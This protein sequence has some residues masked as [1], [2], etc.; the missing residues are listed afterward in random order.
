LEPDV[1]DTRV[2]ILTPENA[3]KAFARQYPTP[4]PNRS[5]GALVTYGHSFLAEGSSAGLTQPQYYAEILAK[6]L[7][8]TYPTLSTGNDLKRAVG[9]SLIHN[10]LQQIASIQ[11]WQPGTKGMVLLQAMLN[12]LGVEGATPQALQ[13]A[14]NG[15]RAAGAF[16]SA[17]QR[18]EL[19][20][21]ARWT[22]SGTWATSSATPSASGT[23]WRSTTQQNAYIEFVAPSVD[24]YLILIG[25]SGAADTGPV[26]AITD[27]TTGGSLGT[28]D[29][30]QQTTAAVNV[31]PH[32]YR[33]PAALGGHLLRFTKSDA[34]TNSLAVD[35]LLPQAAQPVPLLMMKEP[36]L[37]D[38]STS[39][40]FPS[41]SDAAIDAFNA[42]IDEV[43]LE[44]GNIIVADPNGSGYWDK[45][46]HVVPDGVHPNV[47]GNIAL[48]R[49]AID[50]ISAWAARR[51]VALIL[52]AQ[53]AVVD[54]A[55]P[56][57]PTGLTASGA[58]NAVNLAWTGSSDDLGVTGY[59]VYVDG[60]LN[61]TVVGTTAKIMGL[62]IAS[63]SFTVA[64]IDAAGNVSAQS[65]AATATPIEAAY[66][67]TTDSALIS[68]YDSDSLSALAGGANVATWTRTAGAESV[69]LARSTASQQPKMSASAVVGA[70]RGLVF[71]GVDDNFAIT[72]ATARTQPL[73]V[74]AIGQIQNATG[75]LVAGPVN[76]RANID[77]SGMALVSGPAAAS[78][79][80]IYVPIA[81]GTAWRKFGAVV[82]GA[83]SS[84]SV[85]GTRVTGTL[86]T[87]TKIDVLRVGLNS[88]GSGFLNGGIVRLVV[89]GRALSQAE[90]TAALD[91]MAA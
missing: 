3:G 10:A 88:D 50:A 41:R 44:F 59:R 69:A 17:S 4:A 24:S 15:L 9:G 49:T 21:S 68:Y 42:L 22:Y 83:S 86:P 79:A 75:T 67:F 16:I 31:I 8:L 56:T 74:L 78:P 18:F 19:D 20:T 47:A 77:G 70:H 6:A 85:D 57:A 82:N 39:T 87:D 63:H 91:Q 60:T 54:T 76:L 81:T 28:L 29:L 58:A 89:I 7:G 84:L 13:N 72:Y 2:R 48:Y 53:A 33:I 32:A 14:R 62:S 52:N 90:V 51:Q 25:K 65:A 66:D 34:T 30:S 61:S 36:Y 43:A 80:A 27:R 35:V 11:P 1:V 37:N 55:A 40:A 26:V 45:T 64:A 23:T 73:T 71:D 5:A 38:Y 46:A 12:S